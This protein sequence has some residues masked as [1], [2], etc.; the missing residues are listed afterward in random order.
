M[1]GRGP[2]LLRQPALRSLSNPSSSMT[3][4]IESFPIQL[5]QIGDGVE[6]VPT[7]LFACVI[8]H[9]VGTGSTPSHIPPAE[10]SLRK[11][12]QPHLY[13]SIRVWRK[14][15]CPAIYRAMKFVSATLSA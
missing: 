4:S 7:K 1:N 6:P 10:V 13:V 8:V 5:K 12:E 9:M 2:R 3:K 14:R 11:N 15:P